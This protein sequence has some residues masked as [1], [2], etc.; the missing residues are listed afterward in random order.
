MAYTIYEK[1]YGTLSEINKDGELTSSCKIIAGNNICNWSVLGTYTIIGEIS[2]KV[3]NGIDAKGRFLGVF[4][5]IEAFENYDGLKLHSYIIIGNIVYIMNIKDEIALKA[6]LCN[7]L[8]DD[9][10]IDVGIDL[11]R[12]EGGNPFF[13]LNNVLFN[14]NVNTSEL[15]EYRIFEEEE[16]YINKK[17]YVL[18]K[19]TWRYI[20]HYL[21]RYS[22]DVNDKKIFRDE[23]T[24]IDDAS[25]SADKS[26][27]S[28]F[29]AS[30]LQGLPEEDVVIHN[31]QEVQRLLHIRAN[32]KPITAKSGG[33][34]TNEMIDDDWDLNK[35]F[36][37]QV[38]NQKFKN[39]VTLKNDKWLEHISTDEFLDV[40]Q[41]IKDRTGDYEK[42]RTANKDTAT[43]VV[44][45]INKRFEELGTFRKL[46]T[47]D[48]TCSVK[49]LNELNKQ[50]LKTGTIL[51][52]A[53]V[54]IPDGWKLCDGSIVM[55]SDYPELYSIIG[56][57]YNQISDTFD[58]DEMFRLPSCTARVIAG[59]DSNN[60]KFNKVGFRDGM[61]DVPLMIELDSRSHRIKDIGDP[62][63]NQKPGPEEG[64]YR[65]IDPD[66]QVYQEVNQ[67][68]AWYPA[69][70]ET[71]SGGY[72][73][74]RTYD[75]NG[76]MRVITDDVDFYQT[77]KVSR[78][79][80]SPGTSEYDNTHNNIQPYITL[81]MI[82]KLDK[83]SNQ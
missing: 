43:D 28:S 64:K 53:G 72:D 2:D 71:D 45:M 16:S 40:L 25:V 14:Y 55:I 39:I 20:V 12:Q 27:D 7:I 15:L 36:S 23:S 41:S 34:I 50:V 49:A 61:N 30:Y 44:K 68:F 78:S 24:I 75:D 54:D 37:S 21:T 67:V 80:T 73:S 65:P 1:R 32:E 31:M 60:P 46:R 52:Y 6:G 38:I 47:E 63:W 10:T 29:I 9:D 42:L 58:T 13:L 83:N 35:S 62:D 18:N 5:S 56:D 33:I 69:S 3:L 8:N 74:W 51:W 66:E 77:T 17:R 11:A 19:D 57:A 26:Y 79:T 22:V 4:D 59:Y 81:K 70:N 82:I 48:K 76:N